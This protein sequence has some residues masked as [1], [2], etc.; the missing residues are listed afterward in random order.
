MASPNLKRHTFSSP[1][2]RSSPE[3]SKIR[4]L[5]RGQLVFVFSV[6]GIVT[7]ELAFSATLDAVPRLLFRAHYCSL[8]RLKDA[9]MV[10]QCSGFQDFVIL[11]SSN[12]LLQHVATLCFSLKPLSQPYL[13]SSLS[14]THSTPSR[15]RET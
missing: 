15:T 4:E 11:C 5:D 10:E 6:E 12:V 3:T 1:G 2:Q 7:L 9:Y 8:L 14:R 13:A